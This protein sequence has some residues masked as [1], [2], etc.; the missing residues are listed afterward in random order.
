MS[1]PI[2]LVRRVRGTHFIMPPKI[3]G[4]RVVW[5]EYVDDTTRIKATWN[6]QLY[7]C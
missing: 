7:T 2:T 4:D 3:A 1:D 5:L 6:W